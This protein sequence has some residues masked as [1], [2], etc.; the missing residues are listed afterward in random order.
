MKRDT[1][2]VKQQKETRKTKWKKTVKD[3]M[4]QS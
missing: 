3:A 2:N 4:E 1:N